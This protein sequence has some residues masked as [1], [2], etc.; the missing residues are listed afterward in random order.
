MWLVSLVVSSGCAVYEPELIDLAGARAG[1]S[2]S[3]TDGVS[4]TDC[5]NE[6]ASCTLFQA[7]GV[8]VA[9]ECLIASCTFPYGDCDGRADNGCEADLHSADACGRCGVVCRFVHAAASCD[10]DHCV[11]AACESGYADCD[12]ES[13]NGCERSIDTATD[14]GACDN[15]CPDPA[16]ASAR[17]DR[18][19]CAGSCDSGF[20][21]CNQLPDDGCEH[22]LT[23][24]EHCGT[25]DTHCNGPHVSSAACDDGRCVDVVCESDHAD[26]NGDPSDGCEVE[27]GT[28]QDC[29]SCGAVCALPHVELTRCLTK[30]DAAET[31]VPDTICSA[32]ELDCDPRQKQPCAR[33][34]ADCDGLP[35]NGCEAD[36]TRLTSCGRCG[37]S[38][39]TPGAVTECRDGVCTTARCAAGFA[40]C[41]D[42]GSCRS[43]ADDARNCGACGNVCSGPGARCIGGHC[44]TQLC[45]AG[46]ADCDDNPLSFCETSLEAVQS[47]GA[48]GV[49]CGPAF[50]AVLGCERGQCVVDHCQAGFGDCDKDP[51]NGCEVGL[52]SLDDCGACG[53]ACTPPRALAAACQEATCRV[54]ACIP[55]YADCN[56]AGADG[57]ET[58]LVTAEHCGSCSN[59]CHALPNVAAAGC[60]RA[61][62]QI[63]RCEVGFADCDGTAANGCEVSLAAPEHC[64]SCALDCG[65]L[66]HV[67]S[68][69]CADGACR[70]LECGSEFGDCNGLAADGCERSLLTTQDCG[71]CEQ[72]C[73]SNHA[74]AACNAGQ[75]DHGGCD[76]GYGDC[77]GD[78][79]NGCET[80]LDSS[81]HCGACGAACE[82]GASCHDGVCDCAYD[83]Q[84][85]DGLHCCDGQCVDTTGSCF[86]F[87]CIP[88]TDRSD[89]HDRCGAC[90]A[91]CQG[92]CCG[93]LF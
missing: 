46:R 39:V 13:N 31:C 64:G 91:V 2:G 89:N 22:P 28:L 10:D 78:A 20:G 73:Q 90:G 38:C 83:A 55:G 17:C 5:S 66:D 56:D 6:R 40:D 18:G 36:L 42:S 71:T 87:P 45:A 37:V 26:C 34:Y 67:G 24:V 9:G 15:T 32:D 86:P 33:G 76:E 69:D 62:C 52:N 8:C 80:S 51:S 54:L 53:V 61:G 77:D 29:G 23:D 50:Q 92:W 30:D 48:C 93:P 21:D 7:S 35:A 19:A 47:C 3:S 14:C 75:C 57:C 70:V 72:T 58:A 82:G 16:H 59:D 49:E 68:A 4:V 41:A 25:C 88:S 81:A 74:Q 27:L 43:L 11:M 1:R 84:C 12:A 63:E 79:A 44:T 60:V 65:A 85:D